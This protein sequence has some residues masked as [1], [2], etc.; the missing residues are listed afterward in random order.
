MREEKLQYLLSSLALQES[1]Q[2]SPALYTL[3]DVYIFSGSKPWKLV[4]HLV[5]NKGL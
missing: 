3:P 2:V 5:W 4:H 1:K